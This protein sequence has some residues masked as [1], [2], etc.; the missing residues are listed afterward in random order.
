M[1]CPVDESMKESTADPEAAVPCSCH[2]TSATKYDVRGLECCAT[3]TVQLCKP[4]R[5]TVRRR[6][7]EDLWSYATRQTPLLGRPAA[8]RAAVGVWERE[9]IFGCGGRRVDGDVHEYKAALCLNSAPNSMM[10]LLRELKA[11]TANRNGGHD[12]S[13]GVGARRPLCIIAIHEDAIPG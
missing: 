1:L 8:P 4:R 2:A 11:Q 12:R 10:N 3:S 5:R 9:R 7:V 6:A 13:E